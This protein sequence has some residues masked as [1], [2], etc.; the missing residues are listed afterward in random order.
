M[1]LASRIAANLVSVAD[2]VAAAAARSGRTPA[3]VRLVAVSK[4]FGIDHVEAAVAAGLCELGENKVQEAVRKKA[5]TSA[6]EITWHCI[7]HLQSNKARVAAETFDWIHSVDSVSLLRRLD[8]AATDLHRSLSVL[9]Q[10]D[11]A[12]EATKH[13]GSIA[14]L[15]R[16][17]DAASSC[18]AVSVRGL[19][20]LPPWSP[21][22]EQTRPF[23][24]QLRQLRDECA[25]TGGL[26]L[27]HLSMGMSHDFEVAI[28]EGATI[29]RVG[30]ALFGP[31]PHA[32]V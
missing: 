5:T 6:R 4:T 21:D 22:P 31:R 17:I 15:R 7:G 13:G 24:R 18:A 25:T 19:M 2:R 16:V 27:D 9:V 10:V 12:G 1:D 23:F 20:V 3:D 14:E 26:Q 8:R 28:E 29:V 11:L 32:Q 30:T